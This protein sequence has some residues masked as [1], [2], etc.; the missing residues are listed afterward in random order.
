MSDRNARGPGKRGVRRKSDACRSRARA[1]TYPNCHAASSCIR[2]GDLGGIFNGRSGIATLAG[3]LVVHA[4]LVVG[5]SS[6]PGDQS[7]DRWKRSKRVRSSNWSAL[8]RACGRVRGAAPRRGGAGRGRGRVGI[9]GVWWWEGRGSLGGVGGVWWLWYV[10]GG[11]GGGGV[12]GIVGGQ[13]S[14]LE[15]YLVEWVDNGQRTKASTFG[16]TTAN[17]AL[18]EFIVLVSWDEETAKK[19]ASLEES[20]FSEPNVSNAVKLK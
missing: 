14:R 13:E 7:T 12:W 18:L 11:G 19:L 9:R 8:V 17:S 3:V 5:A 4:V 10:V 2:R 1:R 16:L 15:R 20:H 6:H